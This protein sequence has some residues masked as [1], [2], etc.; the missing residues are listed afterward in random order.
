MAYTRHQQWLLDEK[1]GG[2]PTPAFAADCA[3]LEKGEPLA[4][5]IGTIPFLSATI[6]LASRPLIPRPETEYW[7]ERTIADMQQPCRV[8]DLCAGSGCI[9]IAV[10]CAVPDV[11]VDFVEL[12][13][14]HHHTIRENLRRNDIDP[15]RAT[16]YGGDLF[17]AVPQ[18][19]QYEYILTNP[20]YLDPEASAQIETSVLAYEPHRAL[21][22]G[23]QGM[24]FITRILAEASFYLASQ[25]VLVI[26]HEPEQV[27][28]L[29]ASAQ[30][31]A[32]TCKTYPD[33]WGRMR[34]TRLSTS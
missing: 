22:G 30:A 21:F 16:I 25:G 13:T 26:E 5:L 1:Y 15:A 6:T 24:H 17:S 12:D 34:Y 32:Y 4:Y 11:H 7:V 27:A 29:H 19:N 3:R 14:D 28:A 2:I 18:E 10:L 8:L 31:Y 20:P 33:Q 9:G 23:A